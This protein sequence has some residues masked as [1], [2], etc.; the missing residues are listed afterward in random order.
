MLGAVLREMQACAPG[1]SRDD[2]MAL[3]TEWILTPYRV[4][5]LLGGVGLTRGSEFH[6]LAT[7]DFRLDRQA[8]RQGLQPLFERFGFLTTRLL[9]SDTANQR[10]NRLF[11]FKPTWADATFQYFMMT[12]LPFGERTLCQ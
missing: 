9:R 3:S 7:P 6:F 4:R 12:E 1:T 10:F 5:G 2:L 8:L 11:G